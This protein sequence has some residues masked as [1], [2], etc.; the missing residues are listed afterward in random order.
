MSNQVT[1]CNHS[2]AIF[3]SKKP[4]SEG[5]QFA[6]QCIDAAKTTADRII[7]LSL[8]YAMVILSHDDAQANQIASN[9]I[10]AVNKFDQDEPEWIFDGTKSVLA[11]YNDPRAKRLI[12]LFNALEINNVNERRKQVALALEK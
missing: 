2:E 10:A 4:L 11:S 8:Q 5:I 1:L 9:L 3:G 6:Q 7:G 12:T